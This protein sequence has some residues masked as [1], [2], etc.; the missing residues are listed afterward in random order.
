MKIKINNTEIDT[1]KP[2]YNGYN[3]I[4]C[5]QYCNFRRLSEAQG[6]NVDY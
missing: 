6:L 2:K 1:L 5:E 3:A 4:T